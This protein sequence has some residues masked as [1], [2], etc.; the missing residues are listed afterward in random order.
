MLSDDSISLDKFKT[1][2]FSAIT[3]Y[4]KCSW[5]FKVKNIDKLRLDPPS[6]WTH[7]GTWVHKYVQDVVE[8]KSD[9]AVAAKRFIRSWF[10]FCGIYRKQIKEQY[11]KDDVRSLY[12][13]PVRAIMS[14]REEFKKQFGTY[15]VISVEERLRETLEKWPQKFSGFIDLIIELP[16]GGNK[17][18]VI[19]LKTCKTHFMFRKYLDT[20]KTYQ[21]IYY[22]HFICSKNN[23]DPKNAEVYFVTIPRSPYEKKPVDF[24]RITSGPRK[25][26][27]AL[28]ILDNVL[29]SANNKI[30]VKNRSACRDFYGKECPYFKT[31]YCK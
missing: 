2:S 16:E 7:Y 30:F 4:D 19:D 5:Y 1:I 26:K 22:K 17:R 28:K 6:I 8:E 10:K 9:P 23:I 12:K 11:P 3:D 21:L 31:E 13:G 25:T 24:M 15:K 29:Y 20:L 14:V 18:I 27:N